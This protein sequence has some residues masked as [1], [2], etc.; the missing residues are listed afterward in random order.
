MFQFAC[1]VSSAMQ[2]L[3]WGGLLQAFMSARP[4]FE[5]MVSIFHEVQLPCYPRYMPVSEA[6]QLFFASKPTVHA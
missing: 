6:E 5:A 3:S 2:C 1:A 4:H